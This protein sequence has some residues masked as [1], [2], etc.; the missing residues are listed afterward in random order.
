MGWTMN[1]RPKRKLDSEKDEEEYEYSAEERKKLSRNFDIVK[2]GDA[3]KYI[4]R[5]MVP[6]GWFV[7]YSGYREH[8]MFFYPDK[9]HKWRPGKDPK[10]EPSLDEITDNVVTVMAKEREPIYKLGSNHISEMS[11]YPIIIQ[12]EFPMIMEPGDY[13]HVYGRPCEVTVV[14]SATKFEVKG[15]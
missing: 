5:M 9:Y 3:G 14:L 15:V 10:Y 1:E 6:G 2:F 7:A 8:T 13:I 4:E 12:L 11:D